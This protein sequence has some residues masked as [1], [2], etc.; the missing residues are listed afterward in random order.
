[1]HKTIVTKSNDTQPVEVTL[2]ANEQIYNAKVEIS[3]AKPI[4]KV[5]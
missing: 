4:L 2:I 3:F 1:M 5:G